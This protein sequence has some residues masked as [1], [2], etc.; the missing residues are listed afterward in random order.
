MKKLLIVLLLFVSTFAQSYSQNANVDKYKALFTVN[1]IRFIGW[2]EENKQGDFVIGVINEKGIATELRKNVDGKKFGFQSFVVKDFKTIDE[3]TN[4]NILYVSS[5]ILMNKKNTDLIASK[6]RK[7]TLII[8]ETTSSNSLSMINF[9]A[10][11]DKLKFEINIATIE[12]SGLQ[13]SNSLTA[14]NNAIVK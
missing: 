3:I 7:S 9:V 8:S 12:K 4:C 2:T 6:V 5:S 1:F 11:D 10:V 13:I 14:L